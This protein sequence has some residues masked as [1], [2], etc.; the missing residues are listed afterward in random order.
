MIMTTKSLNEVLG[1][2][3]S[4]FSPEA[5]AERRAHDEA[6]AITYL[7]EKFPDV[8][9]NVFF[10]DSRGEVHEHVL[11]VRSVCQAA[12]NEKIC[13]N[14][15]GAECRLR[16]RPVIRVDRGYLDVRWACEKTCKFRPF[17]T[18]LISK[19][20]LY[21]SQTA[22][23]F[24]AFDPMFNKELEKAKTC[25]ILAAHQHT[26]LIL[27]GGLG[28]GKTHLAIAI[29]LEVIKQGHQAV[30]WTVSELLDELK[31]VNF[32]GGQTDLLN[33]LKAVPCLVLDG[34]G[35]G[36]SGTWGNQ[37][38]QIITARCMNEK[39]T[40]VTTN[41]ASP[42]DFKEISWAASALSQLLE[43]GSWV[44]I[45]KVDDY[46]LKRGARE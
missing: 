1:N 16:S 35:S 18:S 44:M 20:R 32:E 31:R 30:F 25:A 24:E 14:C 39:Q 9:A 23:T 37:L 19:S 46:R 7:T 22:K 6:K 2:K 5:V 34:F 17:K 12:D 28:V 33:E 8:D 26:P 40:V 43:K 29:M 21:P 10:T 36:L 41:A 11:E 3:I 38:Y 15:N 45:R 27:S 42:A 4:A 13:A